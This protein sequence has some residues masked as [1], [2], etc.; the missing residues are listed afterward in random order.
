[1]FAGQETSDLIQ[2]NPHLHIT[3]KVSPSCEVFSYPA[4]HHPLTFTD[5][6]TGAALHLFT[7]HSL[8]VHCE[9]DAVLGMEDAEVSQT[10]NCLENSRDKRGRETLDRKPGCR[11]CPPVWAGLPFWVAGAEWTVLPHD[12]QTLETG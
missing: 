10:Q 6:S 4:I 11:C 12:V 7:S 3:G 2:C 8:V 5:T 1:M 9:P